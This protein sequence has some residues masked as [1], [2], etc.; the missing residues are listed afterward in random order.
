MQV[1]MRMDPETHRVSVQD[2]PFSPEQ[3]L[4]GVR[5]EGWPVRS[6]EVN[7]ALFTRLLRATVTPETQ[8]RLHRQWWDQAAKKGEPLWQPVD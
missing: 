4:P 1:W 2:R 5:G 7:K 3:Q 6:T 8:D